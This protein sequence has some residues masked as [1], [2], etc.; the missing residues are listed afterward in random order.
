MMTKQ[1]S[2][3]FSIFVV[4]VLSLG[5]QSSASGDDATKTPTVVPIPIPVEMASENIRVGQHVKISGRLGSYSIDPD[6]GV[7]IPPDQLTQFTLDDRQGNS[8]MLKPVSNFKIPYGLVGK[9]VVITGKIKHISESAAPQRKSKHLVIET[10]SVRE[11]T[12]I[13]GNA[14][15]TVGTS[16]TNERWVAILCRYDG[17]NNVPHPVVWYEKL[18]G[19]IYPGADHFWREQSYNQFSLS[20]SEVK[21]WYDLPAGSDENHFWLSESFDYRKLVAECSQSADINI[22]F[23]DFTG[24]VIF[25][26]GD[27]GGASQ[28]SDIPVPLLFD[29]Q[30]R[31]YKTV[32]LSLEGSKDQVTVV[33]EIGHTF[34]FKHS[35]GPYTSPYD[36]WWDVMSYGDRR[37]APNACPHQ[38]TPYGCISV[39]TIAFN[40]VNLW[41]PA[42]NYLNVVAGQSVTTTIQRLTKPELTT[43]GETPNYLI[44]RIPLGGGELYTVEAREAVGYDVD[45]PYANAIVI[46][47]AT[48]HENP[49]LKMIDIDARENGIGHFCLNG[50]GAN[51][52]DAGAIWLPGQTFLDDEH[53]VTVQVNSYDPVTSTFNVTINNSGTPSPKPAACP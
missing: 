46:H 34:G 13:Q 47:K 52:N 5:I 18:L 49:P 51:P 7:V 4:L 45:I 25:V 16:N 50:A 44:A 6:P 11:I 39:G 43:S 40:K 10:D 9:T 48:Q 41:I 37:T 14:Q 3:L 27:A 42:Q 20:G 21:G 24:I 33:H 35:S 38:G 17:N 12:L 2:L 36:S 26:N 15:V 19:S 30:E 23:P 8:A 53:G 28:G 1:S 31:F 22:Y 29:G 32:V